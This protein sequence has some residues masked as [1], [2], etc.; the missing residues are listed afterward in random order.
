MLRSDPFADMV[1]RMAGAPPRAGRPALWARVVIVDTRRCV[2]GAWRVL[3]G[4]AARIVDDPWPE[5]VRSGIGRD[6]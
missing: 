3:P 6:V 4:S 5:Y 2:D 1:R